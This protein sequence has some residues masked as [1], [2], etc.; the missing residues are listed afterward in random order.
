MHP[1]EPLEF[2]LG[3]VQHI[4]GRAGRFDLLPELGDFRVV[5]F[6]LAQ[7]FLDRLD[8]LSEKVIAL[9]LGQLGT[10]LLLNLGRK[11][12]NSELACQV[13][14]EPL[15]P[16]ADVDLSKQDLP[17]FNRERQARG[18]QVR[19]SAWLTGVHRRDLELFGNLLALIDHPLKQP[20]DVMNQGV[21]FDSLFQHLL[22]RLHLAD[23]IRFGLNDPHQP[24][25]RLSLADNP[26]GP[27]RKLQHLEHGADADRRKKIRHSRLIHFGVVLARQADQT[28]RNQHIIHQTNPT[29]TVDHQRHDRLRENDV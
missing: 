18:Q 26:S 28:F 2:S 7:L 15:E 11:L 19:Q 29:G 6:R 10:N 12:E 5:G 4:V 14:T 24:G 3:F 13:L 23:Q 8:L 25:S 16:D 9:C 17:F 27:V 1:R 22:E 20:V 21:E